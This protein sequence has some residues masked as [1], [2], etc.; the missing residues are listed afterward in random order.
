MRKLLTIA[1]ISLVVSSSLWAENSGFLTDYSLLK[2]GTLAFDQEYIAPGALER[3][4][5][6]DRVMIDEPSFFISE[7]SKYKGV[8]PSDIAEVAAMMRGAM[9]DGV[10]GRFPVVDAPRAGAVLISWAVGNI[11]L[12]KAKRGLL[13]YTPIGA[14]AYGAKQLA[15]DVVDKTRAYDVVF[16]FEATDSSTGEILFAFVFE[17]SEEDEVVEFEEALAFAFGLGQRM[18]CRL[19]NARVSEAE[20]E[21][22]LQISLEP[23]E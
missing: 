3:I 14:V 17:M 19:H 8:K 21:D 2:P 7:D 23:Q 6:F 18:G 22:C 12:K 15:S 1:A 4:A 9:V 16:E 11:R 20:K 10:S 5:E 13:G